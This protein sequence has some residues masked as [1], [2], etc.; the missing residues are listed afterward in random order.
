M[1]T[2]AGHFPSAG[3]SRE[4]STCN[5]QS[6]CWMWHTSASR[7]HR[8]ATR[9]LSMLSRN[10]MTSAARWTESRVPRLTAR[11][12]SCLLPVAP[13]DVSEVM[14]FVRR[15]N[16]P[17]YRDLVLHYRSRYIIHSGCTR[18]HSWS[19]QGAGSV[20]DEV[21][22]IFHWR[23]P[24]GRTG[25]D[26]GSIINEYRGYLMGVKGGRCV[27]LTTL[28]HSYADNLEIWELQPLG[29]LRAFPGL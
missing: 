10:R 18:W 3:L 17:V 13:D 27:R 28:P 2:V 21:I 6:V 29:R 19:R 11:R 23:N 20:P 24:S 5:E 1:T 12:P 25:F 14:W 26:S 8:F 4:T 9:S 22:E 16:V 7:S 15:N